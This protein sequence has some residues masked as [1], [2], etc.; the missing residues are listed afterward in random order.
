MITT[1]KRSKVLLYTVL[2]EWK[3]NLH[4]LTSNFVEGATITRGVGLWQGTKEDSARIEIIGS[5]EDG[6]AVADLA[7]AI[8]NVNNQTAV[9]VTETDITLTEYL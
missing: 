7:T 9:Y 8:R 5:I 1:A 2:T 6:K 4:T 3:D